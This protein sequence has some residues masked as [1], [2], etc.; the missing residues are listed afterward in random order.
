MGS[1]APLVPRNYVLMEVKQNLLASDRKENLKVFKKAHFR[2]VAQVMMGEPATDFKAKVH[3]K[4]LELK[5]LKANNEWKNKKAEHE[6]KRAIAKRQRELKEKQAKAAEE[7]KKRKEAFEAKKKEAEDK[8]KEE[9]EDKKK[10][11][12]A[13]KKE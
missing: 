9:A 6:R 1:I 12:E 4:L 13:K 8:K 2:Q 3:A 11:E 7:A 10:E 5:Q